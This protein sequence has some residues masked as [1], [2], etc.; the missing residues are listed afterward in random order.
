MCLIVKHLATDKTPLVVSCW[1]VLVHN[2]GL[3]PSE[4][5]KTPYE[6][7][8]VP[9]DGLLV[10]NTYRALP[11]YYRQRIY[12]GFI[13]SLFT[14]RPKSIYWGGCRIH[15]AYAIKP[16]AFGNNGD[17]ISLAL[18]IPSLDEDK[19]RRKSFLENDQTGDTLIELFPRLKKYRRK[20]WL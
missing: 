13:H 6:E 16:I 17:L 20:G 8:I 11:K 14:R 5:P 3:L 10:P 18:Y 2:D 1:K 9:T 4:R 19:Q 15:T 7:T 12:G